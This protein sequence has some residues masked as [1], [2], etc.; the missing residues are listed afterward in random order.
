MTLRKHKILVNEERPARSLPCATNPGRAVGAWLASSLR[1]RQVRLRL[2]THSGQDLHLAILPRCTASVSR[3]VLPMPGSSLSKVRSMSRI[4]ATAHGDLN[5]RPF[6]LLEF[7]LSTYDVSGC[8]R[9]MGLTPIRV[10]MRP[11]DVDKP[12]R[13]RFA[14]LWTR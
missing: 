13:A 7:P 8:H 1:E 12:S 6:Q 9:P 3:A 5:K 14:A 11:G 2:D 10:G 4:C